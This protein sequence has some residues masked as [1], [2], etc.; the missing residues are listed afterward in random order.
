MAII[1]LS[2]SLFDA[3][4]GLNPHQVDAVLFAPELPLAVAIWK[5]FVNL[6]RARRFGDGGD[7]F[8]LM[9]KMEAL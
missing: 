2:V 6:Y 3:A 5:T 4:V 7:S 1:A 9:F 8:R